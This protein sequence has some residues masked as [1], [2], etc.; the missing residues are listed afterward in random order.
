MVYM[1]DSQSRCHRL[2]ALSFNLLGETIN[3][4]VQ[5]VHYIS[6]ILSNSL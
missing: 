5:G 3:L 4:G 2:D 1:L 6:N